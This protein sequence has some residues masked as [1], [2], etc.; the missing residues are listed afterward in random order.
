[1][2]DRRHFVIA[3]AVALAGGA[4]TRAL[5]QPSGA[6]RVGV[7]APS[8]SVTE[9]IVLKP[10]FD[11]MGERGWEEGRSIVYDRVF[12]DDQQ[13]RLAGLAVELVSRK[14]DLIYAPPTPA[15]IA[16]KMATD[17]IPI[18]FGAV[19]DPVGSG[20]V[21]SLAHPLGNVT[22]ISVF[23]ESLGPKR[24]Q[25]LQEFLPNV[26][27]FG[28]LADSTDP[29]T[30]SERHSLEPY[31]A[32]N[33]I[34]VVGAEGANPLEVESAIGHLIGEHVDV[35]YTGTSPLIYNLRDR[36][37]AIASREH[38]PVIAYRSQLADAGALFSYGTS[39]RD[40]IRR[41]AL[42]VDKILRGAT[43]ASLPV[44]QATMFELVVN[45]RTAKLLGI[46]VPRSILLRA[47]RVIE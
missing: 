36:L 33:G 40:Q 46:T 20:L 4:P 25:L 44:E 47:D 32:S 27:R 6:R 35:I 3:A 37:M 26:K 34:I 31:A 39:L 15:A 5:S 43:P 19:W 11:Q 13:Q 12:A 14:P 24:L 8:T 28:W 42:Y 10:F 18:V 9:E 2:H 41:S 29:T 21:S 17:T 30:K 22:G 45:A 1:M 23:S 7:L 16:A 38:I